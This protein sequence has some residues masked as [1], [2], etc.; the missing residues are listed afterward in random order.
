M[1]SSLNAISR[2]LDL[3]PAPLVARSR[4]R[5]VANGDSMELPGFV[6]GGGVERVKEVRDAANTSTIR[7]GV[8]AAHIEL[9]RAGRP[10]QQLARELEP[11]ANAIR[12]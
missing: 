3:E 6:D 9:A 5:T 8:P 4:S 10:I 12:K 7:T 11:S 1:S 2:P